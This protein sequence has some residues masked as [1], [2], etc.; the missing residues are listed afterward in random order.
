MPWFIFHLYSSSGIP[1]LALIFYPNSLPSTDTTLVT[2]C[3]FLPSILACSL[4][5]WLCFCSQSCHLRKKH[6]R[7]ITLKTTITTWF[8]LPEVQWEGNTHQYKHKRS[9]A[10]YPLA[11]CTSELNLF[12]TIVHSFCVLCIT[13]YVYFYTFMS[14]WHSITL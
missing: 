3:L 14:S 12:S 13:K 8:V 6:T 9:W 10:R 11:V 1:T 4:F 2:F 7:V 5:T